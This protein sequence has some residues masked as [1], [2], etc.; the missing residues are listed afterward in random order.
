MSI[1]ANGWVM[2]E[3][4]TPFVR[5]D[6]EIGPL[7]PGEALIRVAGC[8]VCHT[9]I[10]FSYLGVKTRMAPP[11][12]L[13]HEISGIVEEVSEDADPG[14]KGKAVLVPA[15]LPC[16]VCE[17]CRSDNRR[18]CTSQIMPGNDRHGGFASHVIVPAKFICPIPEKV[19]ADHELWELAVVSDAIT[20]PFQAVKRSG[21]E[22]GQLAICIGVGGIGIHGVQVAKGAGAKVIALDVDA[23]KLEAA[24]QAGADAVI[25]VA[26]LDAK[27][28]KGKIKEEVKRLQAPKA[29]WKIFETSGTKPGQNTAFQLMG[30]GS[31]VAM[32]GFTMDKLEVRLSNLMAFD[33]SMFGIWGCDPVLYPEVLEWIGQKRIRV[34]PYVEKHSL[35]EINSVFEASHHGKLQ[36]R[37]VLVP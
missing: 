35:E 2:T 13:G 32:V 5:Q 19:L 17:M 25:N 26:G 6:I 22:A 37:A 31:T 27:E 4:N 14:L 12:V 23:G 28:L 18:I 16:G 1:T 36:K 7:K 20:T 24:S 34:K 3:P 29:L 15:V 8:G 11:L 30:F 10:S 21:L 33:A 9:D